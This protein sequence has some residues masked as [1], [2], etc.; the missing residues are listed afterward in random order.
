MP[1]GYYRAQLHVITHNNNAIDTQQCCGDKVRL[2]CLRS[3]IDHNGSENNITAG[4]AFIEESCVDR[5]SGACR[6]NDPAFLQ[7]F[8]FG[9]AIRTIMLRLN[10]FPFLGATA[11]LRP[12]GFNLRVVSSLVMKSKLLEF[13]RY[14]VLRPKF[15]PNRASPVHTPIIAFD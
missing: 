9:C 10:L 3:L 6:H 14:D 8:F 12:K 11:Q 15:L 1:L 7:D 5:R 4:L 2:S 13:G